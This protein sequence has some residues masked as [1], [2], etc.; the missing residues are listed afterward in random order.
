MSLLKHRSDVIE[1]EECGTTFQVVTEGP[2]EITCCPI[3][4]DEFVVVCDAASEDDEDE[5]E[6][7]DDED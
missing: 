2:E 3:C 4:G 1:C 7:E 6:P 5:F